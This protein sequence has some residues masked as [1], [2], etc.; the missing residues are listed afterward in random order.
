MSGCL[1]YLSLLHRAEKNDSEER[2]GEIKELRRNAATALKCGSRSE[3]QLSGG[4]RSETQ[5]PKRHPPGRLAAQAGGA[6]P[7]AKRSSHATHRSRARS[8][9]ASEAHRAHA[10]EAS[11]ASLG[12]N[13]RG[14]KEHR[15]ERSE[16][17]KGAWER[18]EGAAARRGRGCGR[19]GRRIN[20]AAERRYRSARRARS[21]PTEERWRGGK[22]K[23]KGKAAEGRQLIYFNI[24]VIVLKLGGGGAKRQPKAAPPPNFTQSRQLCLIDGSEWLF[25]LPSSGG[26]HNSRY[27]QLPSGWLALRS[28]RGARSAKRRERR[29]TNF[30]TP[31]WER[32]R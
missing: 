8:G 15:R 19:A 10:D 4:S 30:L 24:T 27:L 21:S 6:E 5:F 25:S 3:T 16:A 7:R 18:S 29:A 28:V 13:A 1:Q 23:A 2:R 22:K 11:E 14:R 9:G 20:K 17:R 26:L 32:R 31:G 12:E